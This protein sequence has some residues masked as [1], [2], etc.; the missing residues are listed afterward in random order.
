MRFI[1][2]RR[3]KLT[4]I[5]SQ[6]LLTKMSILMTSVCV[7]SLITS[8]EKDILTDQPDW[9]GN[10]IY[11]RLG[12]GIDV[13]GQKKTFKTTLRLID[14]LGQTEVLSHTGS[15]TLFVADDKTYDKWFETNSWGVRK[16]EQLSNAQKKML[17]NHSMINNAYL[18]SLMSNVSGNPPH[19]GMCMR[20]STSASILD[21]VGYITPEQMPVNPFNLSRLDSWAKYREAGKKMLLFKDNSSA[22]MI[23]FLPSF[24]QKNHIDGNDLKVLT[25][26]V[27]TSIDDAWI[28]GKKVISEVQTC[29]N[30]YIYVVD[31]VIESNLNMAEIIRQRKETSQW[32]Q[33]IDRFSAPYYDKKSSD[34]YN[35]INNTNDSVYT[36]RYFSDYSSSGNLNKTPDDLTVPAKLTFDPGWN[37]YMYTNSMNYDMHYDAGVMIVPT[38]SALNAWWNGA[39]KG[40]KEEYQTWDNVPALTLSK[41]LRV[42]MLPSFIDAVPSKFPTIVDDSKVPLGIKTEDIKE[43][44]MGCNGVIYLVNKVFAPSEYR[45]VAYPALAHQ[46]LMRVVYY[47]ID[48][49][50][51]GP[52]LNSMDSRFSLILPTNTAMLTYID[53]CTYGLKSKTMFEFYYDEEEQVVRANKYGVEMD[54]NGEYRIVET[55]PT[56]TYT[57]S[58][59]MSNEVMNRLSDLIDNLIVVGDIEDGQEYYKTKA[60]SVIRVVK[61]ADSIRYVYG[62]YQMDM[63]KPVDVAKV[64]DMTE[65]GNGKSYETSSIPQTSER[66]VF[67]T[68]KNNPEYSLFFSLIN[69]DDTQDGFF[70]QTSGSTSS[71]YY[72]ANDEENKNIRLFDKY[73]YTVYVPTNKSIQE[74]IDKG[75]LPTWE[76][77]VKLNDDA[78]RGDAAAIQAQK[79]IASRIQNFVRYHIQDNSVYIG[80]KPLNKTKYETSKL[81]P[82]NNRFYSLEVTSSASGMDVK[83]YLDSHH[84]V[85]MTKGLYNNTCSEYW[86]KKTG[87]NIRTQTRYLYATSHAVV[88]Q[89]DGVLLYDESQKTSWKAEAGIK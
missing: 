15:K 38:D 1:N 13:D 72:C 26:G 82:N 16:Y 27:S 12:E 81:N 33:L 46:S 3:E 7:A 36:L 52:Y 84:K 8:C 73:N 21:T 42:N 2:Q 85:N 83:D 50:D 66:S 29:K 67:E 74:M 47:A 48:N 24:M 4:A 61:E 19:D 37:T 10:S 23:H 79:V 39:G 87:S 49:Y 43:C 88:H 28:N 9:L 89:I 31:G 17:F 60:G 35:R 70:V 64:Y 65:Q 20:R 58:S 25:N 77:Y 34:Q 40:L 86:I 59:N 22:P 41:L 11:E 69:D 63:N 78:E 62:G 18:L 75:W 5:M 76:D 54:E 57:S 56:A 6:R 14:D 68:L 53:P 44:I 45:S 30:G 71:P 55:L 51:F 80:G 32:S